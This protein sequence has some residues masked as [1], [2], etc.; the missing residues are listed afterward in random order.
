MADMLHSPVRDFDDG[1]RRISEL[2]DR[3]ADLELECADLRDLA[4]LLEDQLDL[5]RLAASRLP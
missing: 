2:E 3:I 5:V 1:A 4:T